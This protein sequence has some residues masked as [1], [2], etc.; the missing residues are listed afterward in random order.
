MTIAAGNAPTAAKAPPYIWAVLAV[1]VA[2]QTAGSFAAQGVYIMVP[3]WRDAFQVSLASASL[4]VTFMNSGQILTMLMLGKAIDR[5]G[6]RGVVSLMMFGMGAAAILCAVYAA[7]LWMVLA[8]M[9]LLGTTYAA[10]Q[11]GGTRAIIRW[12]PPKHRGL[13][14]G[15]R[16]A[17]VPLGTAIAAI[18][19][20]LTA[21]AYG[22]RSAVLLLGVVSVAGGLV[23]WLLYREPVEQVS[24]T[25]RVLPLPDL[26]KTVGRNP[27]FWPVLWAGIAMSAFQ[28]TLTA[29]A[30]SYL[31]NGLGFTVKNAASLFSFAQLLGIPGR[32]LLPSL[33][34]HYFPGRRARSFGWTMIIAGLTVGSF[35]VLASGTSQILIVALFILLGVFG[36]GWF[37]LYLLQIAEMAPRSSIASTV[38]FATTLC[39][40]VMALGPFFFGVMVDWFGYGTAWACLVAPVLATAIPLL[41]KK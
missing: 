11:P 2:V 17:A 32:I 15:F 22:W 4:A 31:S 21:N 35:A 39:M 7:S 41:R 40:I 18:A 29:H 19:L 25:E 10:V 27:L 13:A 8:C 12:F 26:L 20:P 23:F 24:V 37:P 5:Y 34:D 38:S 28:F 14:T 6:E 3:I 9:G 36:I 30:I 16:Q 33:S 1:A